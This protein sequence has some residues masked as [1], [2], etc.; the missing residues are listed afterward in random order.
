MASWQVMCYVRN[1]SPKDK[2]ITKSHYDPATCLSFLSRIE[3][4]RDSNFF[5]LNFFKG[6]MKF[7]IFMFLWEK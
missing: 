6:K 7:F 1:E 3:E 5:F 2:F 4:K